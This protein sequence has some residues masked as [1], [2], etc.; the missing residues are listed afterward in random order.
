MKVRAAPETPRSR[1]FEPASGL[2]HSAVSGCFALTT[3]P[4]ESM[5]RASR[6]SKS[7]RS[8]W[9]AGVRLSNACGTR[10]IISRDARGARRARGRSSRPYL[11]HL[12]PL[13]RRQI[14]ML[15]DD[16]IGVEPRE[17]G[18]ALRVF[19]LIWGG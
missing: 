3:G 2:S 4:R 10:S 12:K 16:V 17:R 19:E 14:P 1:R 11:E 6:L 15:G 18:A 13:H 7:D 9:G 8:S 5:D